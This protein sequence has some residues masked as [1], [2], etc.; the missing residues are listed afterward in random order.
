[1]KNH[2]IHILFHKQFPEQRNNRDSC[3]TAKFYIFSPLIEYHIILKVLII[4]TFIFPSLNVFSQKF[5]SDT[6]Y[7]D[8]KGDSILEVG[9][10]CIKE[11]IDHRDEDPRFIMYQ[12]KNKLL[13]FPVDIEIHTK[14][15]IS[16]ILFNNIDIAENCKSYY[17][18]HLNKF[19]IEKRKGKFGSGT[20][21]LADIPVYEYIDDSAFYRGTF[22]YDY[23]YRSLYR[24]ESSASSV[25]NLLCNWHC[26]FKTDLLR[27]NYSKLNETGDLPRNF[28][29]DPK[30]KPLYFNVQA[31]VLAGIDWYGVQGEMFFTR[32]ELASPGKTKSG[33]IRYQNNRDYESLGI[34]RN[35]EHLSFRKNKNLILDIDM[36]ILL[37]FLKWKEVQVHKPT[38]YQI[39]NLELSSVQSIIFNQINKQGITFRF[40]AIESLSYV[41]DKKLR[42]QAGG[43]L[44][45]GYKF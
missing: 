5:L 19:E 37:G 10:L 18:L 23:L 17:S 15:A 4:I 9:P 34:G 2:F 26:A 22:Y 33:I 43:V 7:I 27:L 11:I 35:S 8:F 38:I 12:T 36:N 45:L 28:L 31:T 40:G 32:P 21:L 20:F 6:M 41:Y 16:E 1:M 42:F 25:L 3:F 30:I 44:G 24:R 14:N 39:L 13:L 29:T